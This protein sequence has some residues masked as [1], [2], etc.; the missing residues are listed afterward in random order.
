[1]RLVLLLLLA[2]FEVKQRAVFTTGQTVRKRGSIA[3]TTQD[4]LNKP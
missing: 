1:M 3:I 4:D 2:E